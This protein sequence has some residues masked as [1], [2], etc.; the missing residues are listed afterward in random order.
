MKQIIKYK[1]MNLMEI[2]NKAGDKSFK[3]LP[4]AN[5]IEKEL[6][7]E[8]KQHPHVKLLIDEDI[9][10][11]SIAYPFPKMAEKEQLRLVAETV[12]KEALEGWLAQAKNP[13]VQKA[14][15]DQLEKIELTDEEKVQ[16]QKTQIVDPQ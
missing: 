4:G 9:I 12:N 1:Q 8:L 6:W 14:I 7:D 5:E 2:C 16:R 10:D 15:K 3:L 13:K 11:E